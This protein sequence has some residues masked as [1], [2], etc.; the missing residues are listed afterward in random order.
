[1]ILKKFDELRA[2][3]ELEL[4]NLNRDRRRVEKEWLEAKDME[5]KYVQMVG[6]LTEKATAMEAVQSALDLRESELKKKEDILQK[7]KEKIIEEG[8]ILAIREKRV[9]RKE[10]SLKI[11]EELAR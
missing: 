6:D 2:L 11:E 1:M 10:Q 9:K 4:R 3:V 5:N 7:E 8:S